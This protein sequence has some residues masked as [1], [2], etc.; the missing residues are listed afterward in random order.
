MYPLEVNYDANI[1]DAFASLRILDG[2]I[3]RHA[4]H[5]APVKFLL[6]R[7]LSSSLSNRT[8][9][10]LCLGEYIISIICIW[11]LKKLPGPA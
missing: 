8:L 2:T 4:K 3:P 1:H 9:A 11:N 6:Q 10:L 7:A 5:G